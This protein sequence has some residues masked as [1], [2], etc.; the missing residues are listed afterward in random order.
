MFSYQS[1]S[2]LGAIK[3]SINKTIEI[4]KLKDFNIFIQVY[5]LK[6]NLHN[7]VVVYFCFGRVPKL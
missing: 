5:L 7:I 1:L 6:Y 3:D 4:I 2:L